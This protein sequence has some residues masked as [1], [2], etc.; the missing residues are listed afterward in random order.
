MDQ[1]T[2]TTVFHEKI[3]LSKFKYIVANPSKYEHIIQEQEGVMRRASNYNAFTMFRKMIESATVPN[4]LKGTD[5]A[6]IKVSYAKGAKSNGIGRWY[7]KKAI[8]LQSLAV[9]VRHTICEG[10]WT[11]IDQVNSHPTIFQ[12][13]M[14]KYG[15]HS[16]LLNECLNDREV[17]LKKVGGNRDDAKTKVTA[18]INGAYYDDNQILKQ[19]SAEIKPCINHVINLP[20]YA[21]ILQFVKWTYETNIR[22]KCI[23]RILQIIENDL[24]QCYIEWSIAKGFVDFKNHLALIFD[25]FQLLAEHNITDALLLECVSFA[26]DKTGY[27]IPLKVKPFDNPLII[28]ENYKKRFDVVPESLDENS[29]L[30]ASIENCLANEGAHFS[31]AQIVASLFRDRIVYDA[32]E[33][34]WYIINNENI[35]E[36]HREFL[37]FNTICSVQIAKCFT[38]RGAMIRQKMQESDISAELNLILDEKCKKSVKIAWKLKDT[39]FVA[40][41]LPPC[42]SLMFVPNFS[43]KVIDHKSHL[44]AFTDKV[45]DFHTNEFREIVPTDYIMTT[46]GYNYPVNVDPKDVKFLDDYFECVFPEA[47]K[48]DYVLDSTCVTMNGDRNEQFFNIHTGSGS[49]SKSTY[50]SLFKSA[51]GGYA[52]EVSGETFTKPKKSAN[53]TGELY[54]AKGK[55][56]IFSNEPEATQDK[57]QTALLKRIADESGRTIIARELYSNAIEFAITFILNFFCNTM[58]EL[59]S[60]DG[61]IARRLRVIQW[62]IK[63]V[64]IPNPNNPLERQKDPDFANMMRTDG[65]KFAFVTMMIQRWIDRVSQFKLIPVPQAVVDAGTNYIE[66]CNPVLGFVNQNYILTDN[67]TDKVTSSTVFNDFSA[68]N[69]GERISNKRFKDDMLSI[70]G[71]LWKRTNSGVIFTGLKLKNPEYQ[72]DDSD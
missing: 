48:R 46:T 37:Q 32:D 50:D 58:P 35:W 42:K 14:Q 52:C 49:N 22:G 13:F 68:S 38:M 15:F 1:I 23:S 20:E 65:V 72:D 62:C 44:F 4:E 24:L 55:R 21:E 64:D 57:L 9:S 53:D 8:G 41:I 43:S 16:P 18:I 6:Y 34:S 3:N 66:D 54:K 29:C 39:N 30:V 31:I 2:E 25:G 10:I 47:E 7:C 51:V 27:E 28:P 61:G 33:K 60:I 70:S 12:T 17:F 11:D 59:S 36:K 71:I 67:H 69:G 45:F 26:K 19:L 40:S 63:F 56:V 5:F